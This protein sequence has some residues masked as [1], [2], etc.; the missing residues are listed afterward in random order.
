MSWN[1]CAPCGQLDF[2][3]VRGAQPASGWLL[4]SGWNEQERRSFSPKER[5]VRVNTDVIATREPFDGID[6]RAPGVYFQAVALATPPRR[7]V[8]SEHF[9]ARL[10]LAVPARSQYVAGG[11]P[12]WCSPASLSMIHAYYDRAMDVSEVARQVFDSAYNGSGNWSFNVAYSGRLGLIGVVA[13]LRNLEHAARFIS[14]GIPLT[15][16]YSWSADELPNAPVEHSDGHLAVLRGFNEGGDPLMNDPA[17]AN[18]QE[19]Y[20]REAFE[21][22]W[23]RSGRVAY[24]V[25]QRGVDIAAL[26]NS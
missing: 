22:A 16:S 1:T 9:C 13:Y 14:A 5:G 2:R 15:L 17:S 3:I 25:A 23:S 4:H 26:V 11:E 24:V 8:S 19:I 21:R 10:E 20:P 7:G 18:L 12:G 6:V